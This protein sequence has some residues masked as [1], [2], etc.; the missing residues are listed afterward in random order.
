MKTTF[1]ANPS[2]I[3]RKWFV[4]DAEGQTLGRLAAEVA[5]V[6]RGKHK[7]TFTPHM[8]TGDYVIV[9]NAEKVK[10]TGKKLIKKIY[11]RHSGYPGGATYTQA[12]HML[13]THPERV[14]EMAIKGMIPHT[15]L[16]EQMY[17]KLNVY[18][19][20]E[21]PHQA[22]KPEVLNLDIR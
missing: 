14:V 2:N 9:I 5:K 13:E 3:E 19:G 7:P 17:R 12:G 1:M 18:A 20:P 16:G 8:D 6:L 21:H 10:L 22:Q 4:V 15:K 11:F